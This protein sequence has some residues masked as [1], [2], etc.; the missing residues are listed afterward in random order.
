MRLV[1][2]F[3]AAICI[4]AGIGTAVYLIGQFM[5]FAPDDPYIL[6]RTRTVMFACL[7]VSMLHVAVLG[8]PGFLV[9]RWRGALSW[10]SILLSGFVL[11]A[12]PGAI[13]SW[14]CSTRIC[15]HPPSTTGSPR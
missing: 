7:A 15:R 12:L 10:P 2:A 1:L 5:M 3:L 11:G 4:P 6:V 9:L 13:L 8:I 14:P